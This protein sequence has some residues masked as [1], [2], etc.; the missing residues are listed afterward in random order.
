[1]RVPAL[2][3]HFV[4]RIPS[5]GVAKCPEI[6]ACNVELEDSCWVGFGWDSREVCSRVLR[7]ILKRTGSECKKES[8]ESSNFGMYEVSNSETLTPHSTSHLL[9]VESVVQKAVE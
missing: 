9:V 1:M 5:L 7:M 3:C 2:L 4:L 6:V 8:S